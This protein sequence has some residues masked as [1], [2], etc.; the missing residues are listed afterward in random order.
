MLRK[1]MIMQDIIEIESF[2]SALAIHVRW[3]FV[4]FQ[5]SYESFQIEQPE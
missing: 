4:F 3:D 5:R 2:F 1:N